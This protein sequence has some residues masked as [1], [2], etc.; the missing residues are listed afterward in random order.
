M[1]GKEWSARQLFDAID[2]DGSGE[3]S[4]RECFTPHS[5]ATLTLT[6]IDAQKIVLTLTLTPTLLII[7]TPTADGGNTVRQQLVLGS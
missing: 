1:E 4:R 7:P 2:T 3:I 6:L 5:N